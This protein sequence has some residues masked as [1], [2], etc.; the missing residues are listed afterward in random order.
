MSSAVY[1]IITSDHLNYHQK[2][3]ALCHEA[4]SASIYRRN[5]SEQPP[6]CNFGKCC[7]SN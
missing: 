5:L 3:N 2:L 6:H 7:E 1:D 4:L